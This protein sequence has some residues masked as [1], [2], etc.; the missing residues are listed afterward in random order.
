MCGEHAN[1]NIHHSPSNIS[2]GN[3]PFLFALHRLRKQTEGFFD[4]GFFLRCDVVLF[5]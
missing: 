4:F 5:G 2:Y 3:N 1:I